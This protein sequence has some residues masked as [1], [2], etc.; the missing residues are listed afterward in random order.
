M[1][2]NAVIDALEVLVCIY[3]MLCFMLFV[4]ADLALEIEIAMHIICIDMT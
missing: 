1:F 2:Q 4:I 3:N